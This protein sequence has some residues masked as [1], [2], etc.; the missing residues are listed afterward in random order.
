MSEIQ[1]GQK[2]YHFAYGPVTVIKVT[3]EH[4]GD[5]VETTVDDPHGFRMPGHA[6]HPS[7]IWL[8][9]T[10]GHWIFETPEEVGTENNDFDWKKRWSSKHAEEHMK[11]LVE[12]AAKDKNNWHAFYAK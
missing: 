4:T 8:M 3:S 7:Q 5:Y 6:C 9:D 11:S 10:V 2:L 12:E 1:V